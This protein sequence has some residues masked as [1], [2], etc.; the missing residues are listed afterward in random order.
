MMSNN[1]MRQGNNSIPNWI[2]SDYPMCDKDNIVAPIQ[3]VKAVF[4]H[5][6]RSNLANTVGQIELNNKMLYV[7]EQI[8]ESTPQFPA[9]DGERK[10]KEE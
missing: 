5:S 1:D 10:E 7:V 9:M 8:K 4:A 6:L 3:N 2:I